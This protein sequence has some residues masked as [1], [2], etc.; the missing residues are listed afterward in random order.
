MSSNQLLDIL[1]S[2]VEELEFK[3][4]QLEGK[5]GGTSS[6]LERFMRQQTADLIN[7]GF[8][9]V[10][11]LTANSNVNTLTE[12][13]KLTEDIGVLQFIDPN[14]GARTVRLPAS[15]VSNKYYIVVNTATP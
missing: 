8:A 4:S 9:S 3:M 7:A 6:L 10:I 2:R 13:I 11:P 14:G 1:P 12:D 5:F 15:G